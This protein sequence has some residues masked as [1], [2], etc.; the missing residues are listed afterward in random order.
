MTNIFDVDASILVK[1]TAEKLKGLIKEPPKYTLYVKSGAG[2]ER[3]P[4][5]PDFWYERSAAILRQVYING[6]V[7]VERLRVRYGNKKKHVVHRKHFT[8]A[9]GS[10]IRDSLE[11]LEAAGFVKKTKK[12]RV[13]DSKGISFLDK[14]SNEINQRK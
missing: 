3:P 1:E 6:P 9:G 11:A 12:G 2:R 4:D 10:I 13:I 14:I 5:N 7:G 8:K